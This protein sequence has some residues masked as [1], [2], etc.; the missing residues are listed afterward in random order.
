MGNTLFSRHGLH[1]FDFLWPGLGP[2]SGAH[3]GA[4]R[5]QQVADQLTTRVNFLPAATLRLETDGLPHERPAHQAETA[6]P[7]DVTVG[8]YAPDGPA[9]RIGQAE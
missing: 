8:H 6:L 7:F 4:I 9:R 3:T 5:R 2:E 1:I